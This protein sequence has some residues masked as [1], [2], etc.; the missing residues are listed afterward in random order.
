MESKKLK[1]VIIKEELVELTGNY[2]DAVLLG[3]LLYWSERVSDFDEF[4]KQEA[5]AEN[6]EPDGLR[7]GWIYKSYDELSQETMLGLSKSNIKRHI[8]NLINLGLVSTR[9]N[10][11]RWDN[12]KEYKLNI[13]CIQQKLHKLGYS[14]EGY[15]I[16]LQSSKIE[17]GCSD[18]EQGRS[19]IEQR[20]T[21]NRTTVTEITTETTTENN[22]SSSTAKSADAVKF[23]EDSDE[24]KIVN[25]FISKL[26]SIN[27]KIKVPANVTQKQK[28][29]T[30]INR[31][32]RIDG[33]DKSEICRVIAYAVNDSF[34]RCNVLSA[35]SLRKYYDRLF[36]KMQQSR[37]STDTADNDAVAET[38]KMLEER[39][40]ERERVLKDG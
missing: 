2:V 14:L 6:K 21:Q 33:R 7:Y 10:R 18:I 38:Y 4:I 1:R 12:R 9:Q 34:W 36:I 16:V 40:K 20:N 35:K 8:D 19:K 17:Q 37:K 3:Q 26:K 5:E 13:N 24:M 22:K 27:P 32:M 11:N 23:S 29:A 30:E 25:Y 15:G 28:W 39:R 31:L